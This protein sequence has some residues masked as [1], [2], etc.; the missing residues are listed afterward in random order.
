MRLRTGTHEI[1][2]PEGKTIEWTETVE[3]IVSDKRAVDI[4]FQRFRVPIMTVDSV[5]CPQYKV[6][7]RRKDRRSTS[8]IPVSIAVPNDEKEVQ[9]CS[10]SHR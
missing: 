2:K 5:F 7:H 4:N 9:E 10:S 6:I 3:K 1:R 8:K